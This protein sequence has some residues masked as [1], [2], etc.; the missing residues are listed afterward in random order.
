MPINRGL[1]GLHQQPDF[2]RVSWT[3]A[4]QFNV[5]C[6]RSDPTDSL[7]E[8]AFSARPFTAVNGPGM[9][10]VQIPDTSA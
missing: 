6:L 7:Q 9:E 5:N 8:F 2:V 10:G 1:Q 4:R 3:G